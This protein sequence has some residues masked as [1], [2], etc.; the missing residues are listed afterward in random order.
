MRQ[1]IVAAL[2]ALRFGAAA[3]VH[4]FDTGSLDWGAT[5]DPTSENAAWIANGGNPGG[6]I[7]VTD[8]AVGG[9]WYFDAPQDFTGNKCDAYGKFLR[10]DQFTSDTANQQQTAGR[11]D[12][13][14]FGAGLILAFDN[15]NNPGLSWTHYDVPLSAGAGWRINDNNGPL[16]TETQI[17]AALADVSG[18]R[19]RGEYRSQ[20]DFGGLDNVVLESNFR[21]DL[22]GN[23]DSG[24]FN[25]DYLSDTLCALPAGIVDEDII[26]TSE[27]SVDS[28]RV[29]ILFPLALEQ[30]I[31]SGSLPSSIMVQ[32]LSSAQVTLVNTGQA[33]TS[34]FVAALTAL[35]FQDLSPTP[36]RDT[37]LIEF[38]VFTSCGEA[39][40]VNAYLPVFPKPFAGLDGDTTACAGGNALAL[41]D[42]LGGAPE[43]GGFWKPATVT[44]GVFDPDR[45]APGDYL[46][47]LPDAGECPGDTARVSVIVQQGF[48][49]QNDTTICYEDTLALT[50]PPGLANWQWSDGSRGQSLA[51]TEPGEY[52]LSGQLGECTFSDNINVGF[53]TCRECPFYAP[54]AFSPNYDGDNDQFQVFLPCLWAQFRLEVFDRWGNLVFAADDPET[55]W[56]GAGRGREPVPG[57]YVWR[58]EWT[59]ELFG[60]PRVVKKA[61]DV[62]LVR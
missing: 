40:V 39:S 62:L 32:G 6:Y 61:G 8:A 59:G 28:I 54:N 35:L 26:L 21:F 37:R 2:L 7:R 38:R 12:V 23:D 9:T 29:R 34:D 45:D 50:I 49:L 20:D 22:D 57:V 58:V 51:V 42:L 56:N 4:T 27:A 52:G 46:Y 44:G 3:Q 53:F 36:L 55:G 1:W 19:I 13:L 43:P 10:Y 30:L 47:I 60:Q 15:P 24:A 31:A 18:L 16:A 14:L 25:G 41:F 17:R 5:G 11:P 48:D 33:S